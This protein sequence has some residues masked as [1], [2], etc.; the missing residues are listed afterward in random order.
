MKSI[1]GAS[2]P[3]G[4][5]LCLEQ[6][7]DR[8]L[9]SSGVQPTAAEQLLLEQLNDARANPA[10]YGARI[11]VD[12]SGVAP[13]QPLAFNPD[14]IAAATQ[15]ALDM[16][17]RGYFDHVT[18]DGMDPGQR[19]TIFGVNWASWGE[20]SVAGTNY[21]STSDALHAMIADDGVPDLDHRKQLLAIDAAFQGENQIGI[22]IV[23]NG[24]GPLQNYYTLDTAA[25]DGTPFLTGV[26]YKDINANGH[27]DIGEGV[28]GV[29]LTVTT[30]GGDGRAAGLAVTTFTTW[31]TGG[32]SIA[33]APGNYTVTATGIAGQTIPIVQHVTVGTTNARLNFSIAPPA[34]GTGLAQANAWVALMYQDLLGR[35]ATPDE[36]NL[37]TGAMQLGMT[38]SQVASQIL[39]GD[40]YL[41]RQVVNWFEQYL[42]RWPDEGSLTTFRNFIKGGATLKQAMTEVLASQEYFNNHGG[43]AAGF[44]QGV[45]QDLL[46][47]DVV[48]DEADG[49]IQ[50]GTSQDQ[51]R[52]IIS[53]ILQGTEYNTNDLN[54]L[55]ETFLRRTADAA[56]Q[57]MFLPLLSSGVDERIVAGQILM[58]GE[59]VG[60]ARDVLWIGRMYQEVLGR[61]AGPDE[62]AGWLSLLRSGATRVQVADNIAGSQEAYGQLVTQIFHDLL[63]RDPDAATAATYVNMLQSGSHRADIE[64][65]VVVGP[66]YVAEHG[67]TDDGWVRGLYQDLL[68]RPA[69]DGEVAL[70]V[71]VLAS[72]SR[73]DVVKK[74]T[75]SPEYQQ[76]AL[77]RLGQAYLRRSLTTDEVTLASNA[78]QRGAPEG[79]TAGSILASD[80]YYLAVTS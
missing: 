67:G 33:L 69:S 29:T 78:Q 50:M 16:N 73:L 43:T 79:T 7:E 21:T 15:H 42:G 56:G 23:Q 18:P 51:R 61:T 8:Q 11:G 30:G 27:Y 32:Y 41:T 10:A 46:H 9:L 58:S 13:A 74:I 35:S 3:R 5:R 65:A 54:S 37:W 1:R 59:Y 77:G 76:Y 26:V 68:G 22:G 70:W 38:E 2:V 40:E 66:E 52:A 57:A 4:S 34:A 72:S 75:S 60:S 47:R 14:L 17:A 49:W 48:G 64:A 20:S 55:Y 36:V 39:T 25:T 24:T 44:V 53:G 62:I 45:Y 28:P 63:G 6:L 12:L 71:G 31:N 80:E 19:L